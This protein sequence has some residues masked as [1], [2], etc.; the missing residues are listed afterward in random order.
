MSFTTRN[1]LLMT[2]VSLLLIVTGAYFTHEI[3]MA[4]LFNSDSIYLA[5]LFEDIFVNQGSFSSWHLTPAPYFFPD[6]VLFFAI[7]S[8]VP[9]TYYTFYYYAILQII[10][11][12][13]LSS[14]LLFLISSKKHHL[15]LFSL[16]YVSAV[17]FLTTKNI[18]LYTY[19]LFSAYRFGSFI[20]GLLFLITLVA[21]IRCDSFAK[22]VRACIFLVIW[23]ALG[24]ASD[25]LFLLWFVI[26]S[27]IAII[28]SNLFQ[29]NAIEK[30][31]PVLKIS[32]SSL[33]GIV[34]GILLKNILTD[35]T[36]SRYLFIGESLLSQLR[37][38]LLD[39]SSFSRQSPIA[40][41]LTLLFYS[42]IIFKAAKVI[43][44][45]EF[46]GRNNR[47]NDSFDIISFFKLFILLSPAITAFAL[48]ING[49]FSVSRYLLNVFWFPVIFS[50]VG[51]LEV[52][53]FSINL[54]KYIWFALVVLLGV[55]SIPTQPV[56]GEYYPPVVKCVD[57]AIVAFKDASGETPQVGISG[58]WHAKLITE[59][60]KK[61]AKVVQVNRD[62]SEFSWIN[63]PDWYREAYDFAVVPQEINTIDNHFIPDRSKLEELNGPPKEQIVCNDF[64]LSQYQNSENSDKVE[65]LFYEL[66]GLQT[67]RFQKVGDTYTWYAC[68]L[69]SQIGTIGENCSRDKASDS[70]SGFLT[71]GPYEGLPTGEYI[72]DITYASSADES[73]SVGHWDVSVSLNMEELEEVLKKPLLGTIEQA[74]RVSGKFEIYEDWE[75][76]PIQIRTYV[77]EQ[78]SMSVYEVSL[79]KI[80]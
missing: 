68:E 18:Y 8:L 42:V 1:I 13:L 52:S 61:N 43:L 58:Y 44:S 48:A 41:A 51:Y 66:G 65:I 64:A 40:F 76:K 7:K 24:T 39:L 14:K 67:Q 55:L 2:T 69:P 45:N 77:D 71:F 46:F 9:T 53:F 30:L 72:V 23:V 73:T 25:L 70:G 75:Q 49:V 56:Y 54:I 19:A 34:F 37:I 47:E 63:N 31:F 16:I 35:N 38:L 28:G 79:K 29:G 22:Q 60:S 33:A 59:F 62:L 6:M 3:D 32:L 15:A 57:Q 36:E 4:V 5:S 11:V 20:N 17:F 74:L 50:W 78:M 27:L 10:I 80:S 26:P 21:T 12:Y